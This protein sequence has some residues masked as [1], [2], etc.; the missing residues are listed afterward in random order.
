M[1][2]AL[3][4]L[5]LAVTA[6][7]GAAAQTQT[8]LTGTWTF[9]LKKNGKVVGSQVIILRDDNGKLTGAMPGGSGLQARSWEVNGER[10][11]G[12]FGFVSVVIA[13]SGIY[14]PIVFAGVTQPDGTL[15]GARSDP[16]GYVVS[17][18]GTR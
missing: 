6:M 10:S 15:I 2:H 13:P 7:T 3:I 17:L 8:S 14:A 5:I 9:E 12:A 1:R 18:K 16:D 4:A 11:D